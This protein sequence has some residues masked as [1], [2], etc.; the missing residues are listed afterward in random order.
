MTCPTLR[1]ADDAAVIGTPIRPYPQPAGRVGERITAAAVAGE[2]VERGGGRGEQNSVD[3]VAPGSPFASA[4]SSQASPTAC[5]ITMSAADA[6]AASD[7]PGPQTP[8]SQT[9]DSQTPGHRR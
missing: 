7:S 3:R 2:H 1:D 8:T 4:A 9:P 6:V 5:R